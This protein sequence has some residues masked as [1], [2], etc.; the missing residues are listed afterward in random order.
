MIGVIFIGKESK[1]AA[2]L[3]RVN[4]NIDRPRK[5]VIT[6]IVEEMFEQDCDL[7]IS[8]C[9]E[10][11]LL[12]YD[13]ENY[14]EKIIFVYLY[15]CGVAGYYPLGEIKIEYGSFRD[16]NDKIMKEVYVQI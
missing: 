2:E 1:N 9:L 6:T 4:M 13:L 5:C 12:P 16:L 10:M 11:P 7:V 14:F 3:L 8:H 15:P